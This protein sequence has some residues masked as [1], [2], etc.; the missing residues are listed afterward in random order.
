MKRAG[1]T[2]LEILLAMAL[3]TFGIGWGMTNFRRAT[4]V[5]EL[6]SST[7]RLLQTFSTARAHALSGNKNCEVCGAAGGVCGNGDKMLTGW[8]VSVNINDPSFV[9][10]GY[11]ETVNFTNRL[12]ETIP[13]NIT[14]TSVPAR[15]SIAVIFKPLNQGADFQSTPTIVDQQVAF[16]LRDPVLNLSRT[17]TVYRSGEVK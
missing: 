10:N 2:L 1:F 17:V 13:A 15:S 6:D 9:L 14:L 11:C 7:K 4:R 3:I 5:Q 8:Q 12:A 16:I